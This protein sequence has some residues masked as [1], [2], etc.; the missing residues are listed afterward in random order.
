MRDIDP[1][2]PLVKQQCLAGAATARYYYSHPFAEAFCQENA[3]ILFH[4]LLQDGVRTDQL[5]MITVQPKNRSPHVMVL[6]S[7]SHRF[8]D[9]LDASTPRLRER[10]RPDGLSSEQF[11]WAAY[12]T[13]DTTLLLDPWSRNKAISFAW[14][15][16]PQDVVGI[17]DR[18]FADIGHRNGHPYTVSVTR[19]LASR[20]SQPS[21][22]SAGSAGAGPRRAPVPSE[23]EPSGSESSEPA[24]QAD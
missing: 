2:L 7:E 22:G 10:L 13:R 12:M 3:E 8:I 16:E 11:A 23:L 24:P 9:R 17:L 15:K 21:L 5:R 14:A 18:A 19:P 1:E 4:Y 6:Y 20:R